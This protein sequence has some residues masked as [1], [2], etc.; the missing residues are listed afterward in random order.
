M[1][2][3][4]PS[5]LYGNKIVSNVL[6]S[7]QN[8]EVLADEDVFYAHHALPNEVFDI[9]LNYSSEFGADFID[10][11]E[12]LMTLD[13][14]QN[15]SIRISDALVNASFDKSTNISSI[16]SNSYEDNPPPQCDIP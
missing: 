14:N 12:L 9:D 8:Q 4:K 13:I 3:T 10:A 1:K 11:Q 2:L 15:T 5:F 16:G 6:F 7:N